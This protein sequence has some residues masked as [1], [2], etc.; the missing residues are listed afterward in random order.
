VSDERQDAAGNGE[1]TTTSRGRTAVAAR[2]LRPAGKRSR[3]VATA[4]ENATTA[5]EVAAG[6]SKDGTGT[7]VKAGKKEAGPKHRGPN[8]ILFVFTFL[9]Q[10]VAELRK[11]IWPN[12]RQ[13]VTYTTVV[14]LF[15]AF[16][17]AM[18]GVVDLGLG[19]LV[20]RVFG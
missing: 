19:N 12:R 20:L 17:V 5:P 11:V 14:L 13:M 15:L 16:M 3:Q 4:D 10:V 2:P 7:E 8:P 9:Q 18:I 1:N 6:V